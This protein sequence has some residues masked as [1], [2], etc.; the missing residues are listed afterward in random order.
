M[1][2][3]PEKTDLLQSI[4]GGRELSRIQQ[5]ALVA[6][7][8]VPAILAELSSII[9]QYIDAAMVGSLGADATGAI[10]LV[11]SS[12]WLLGGL[13]T[14][15]AAGF[16]VQ[17]AQFVGAKQNGKARDVFRQSLLTAAVFGLLLCVI[18]V[19][20]SPFL[21]VWLGGRAE[22]TAAASRYFF[23]FSC[24]LPFA[25]FR[26]LAGSMLQ[27]G[28]DMKTPSALNI[29]MCVLDVLFNFL[30]IFPSRDVSLFGAN[31]RIFGAGMG[32]AGAAL[33]T[34]LSEVTVSMLMMYAACVKSPILKLR[35]EKARK[36]NPA[37]YKKAAYISLP[38]AFEHI[39]L[40]GAQVALTHITAPLGTAAI[41]ANSLAVTAESLC[42]MPGYGIGSA[43]TTLV[44]Q[45]IGAG[46]RELAKRYAGLS[47]I[48]GIALMTATGVLMYIFAPFV[49][50]VLTPDA[51]VRLL[52]TQVLRI[53]AFAEPLY[54]ISI[55]TAG[56]L[57]GAGDT[58]IPSILNLV[59]MW[60]VRIT[61]A[62]LLAP[63]FGL[64]GVWLA[65]CGELCVRGILFLIRLA[66]GKW[67]QC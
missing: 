31:I 6:R 39:V 26:Q 23:I 11:T 19:S 61:A 10:G 44:G 50:A 40:C 16:S 14:S 13:C 64:H 32:V 53:E 2:K 49:F 46:R 63:R 52:G 25:Q 66:R 62:W 36:S 21:P 33:G 34:A 30:L 51:E 60:G 47:V 59:S 57:R 4:S 45:S 17:T 54:A 42:Y 9:M 43:A 15:A 8:S 7:L 5:L 27:C 38:L 37:Y 12:S 22:I 20:V 18:G 56:A 28:G 35:K 41:A 65:M 55:V 58:R 29:V 1:I 48:M 24:A 67:L 3:L